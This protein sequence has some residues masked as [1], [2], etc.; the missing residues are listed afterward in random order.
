MVELR[1]RVPFAGR[2]RDRRRRVSRHL[3][4]AELLT[5]TLLTGTATRD[6]VGIDDELAGVGA[7][8]GVSVDPERLQI[9]G[10]ALAAG[11]PTILDVLADVLTGAAH[12]DAEVAAR[13]RAARRADHRRARAAAHD[14]PR[15][16]AA[17]AVRHPPHRPGDADR[18]GRRR[19]RARRRPRRCTPRPCVPGGAILTLVGDL[20]PADAV[21][22]VE[23]RARRLDG[24]APA[25]RLT[26]PPPVAP[27]NLEL[28]HRPGSVQ[29]QL[30]LS[31]PALP[32]LDD[33]ATRRCSWRTSSSAATSRRAGWRTSARTRATPTART[34][35]P[36]SSPA[37]RCWR[38][39][40]TSPATS[41]PPRCWRPATSWAG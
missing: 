37:A 5:A 24:A 16:A 35:A 17:Q 31:A 22:L 26:A 32:R 13:A 12:P 18:P 21:A 7:D 4:A 40:P 29:S 36:S 25:R 14:R 39:R 38:S 20:D 34:R 1:L 28:V 3:A 2:H 11:L 6:R 15:G 30:R 8:L 19:R 27:S 33:R 41:P 9:G 10:S 23:Q